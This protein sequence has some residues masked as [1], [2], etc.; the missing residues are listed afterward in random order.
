MNGG[1]ENHI[2]DHQ[3]ELMSTNFARFKMQHDTEVC[4][5]YLN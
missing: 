1:E 2:S 3:V 4:K 5:V